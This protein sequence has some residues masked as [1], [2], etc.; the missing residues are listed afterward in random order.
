METKI[1]WVVDLESSLKDKL[2]YPFIIF[3]VSG[4]IFGVGCYYGETALKNDLIKYSQ[5]SAYGIH[6]TF[7]F[8]D[9]DIYYEI[10]QFKLKNYSAII[11]DEKGN[12]INVHGKIFPNNP[13]TLKQI[14]LE[15]KI[16]GI[17]II[18]FTI[19]E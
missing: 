19:E 5:S 4:L 14:Q 17:Q 9:S 3:I 11:I 6:Q 12:Y 8:D 18:N 13:I 10:Y 2:F 16:K 15:N 7:R 1:Y